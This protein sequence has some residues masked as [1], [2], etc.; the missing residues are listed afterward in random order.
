LTSPIVS[1]VVSIQ[2]AKIHYLTAGK[3]N[4]YPVLFLHGAS[5]SARTWQE[6]GILEG[7]A[8]AGYRVIAVD[9]PGYGNSQSL[10]GF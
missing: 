5:F 3:P 1:E 10:S 8:Q 9:L 7:V 4:H 2:G 6:I